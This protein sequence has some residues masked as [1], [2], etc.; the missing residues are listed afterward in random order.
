MHS[1]D[2][3]GARWITV[4]SRILRYYVSRK[5]PSRN[6]IDLVLFIQTVYVPVLFWIKKHPSWENGPR[7]F[8]RIICFSRQLKPRMFL[9]IRAKLLSN[10]YFSHPENVL[11][12]M[13]ADKNKAVRE[14]G[15][16]RIIA[17]RK[18]QTLEKPDS[19]VREYKKPCLKHINF[20]CSEYYTQMID[21]DNQRIYEPPFT[22]RLSLHELESFRDSE[23]AI[24]D[25]P[26]IPCHSQATEFCV[27]YVSKAVEKVAGPKKQDAYVRTQLFSRKVGSKNDTKC[28]FVCCDLK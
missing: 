19:K 1:G 13:I 16:N 25:L 8:H 12:S 28:R 21:W 2:I 9:T 14:N 23:S 4:A 5:K 6:L 20:T 17:A 15:Y 18:Q 7:H 27:Q 11:L 22:L 10:S 26:K 24:I 3:Y